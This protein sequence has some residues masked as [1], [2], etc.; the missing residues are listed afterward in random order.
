MLKEKKVY[1]IIGAA[2]SGKRM[3]APLPKQFL[4]IGGRTILE[5]TVEKFD[6]LSLIDEVIIVTAEDYQDFCCQFFHKQIKDG[7]LHVIC[8]G[9]ERQD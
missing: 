8:G 4:K 6:H 7:R 9:A 3:A 5:R 2:G 1:G